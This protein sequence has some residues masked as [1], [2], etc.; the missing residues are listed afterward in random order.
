MKKIPSKYPLISSQKQI[1]DAIK[2]ARKKLND[3]LSNDEI[4]K[5]NQIQ[6]DFQSGKDTVH[7]YS[8]KGERGQL[9][10]QRLTFHNKILNNQFKDKSTIDTRDP[11]LYILGGVPGSGKTEVLGK[12]INEKTVMI[13]NDN[14]K[15]LLAKKDKS[16]IAKYVLAHAALLHE[17]ASILFDKAK[18]R[19]LNEKRDVTLDMTFASFD[20]GKDIIS[21]FKK[22]GYDVHL[23]GT[24]KFVHQTIPNTVSRF[25]KKGRYVPPSVPAKKGNQI[26]RNVLAARKL[27]NT[28]LI[29]DTSIKGKPHL[30]SS[31]KG[32][33]KKPITVKAHKRKNLVN[34]LQVRRHGRRKRRF[35]VKFNR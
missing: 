19:A 26:N 11:D 31:T 23:L 22:A 12:K 30:V 8:K 28:H 1:D 9:I 35:S 5:L 7:K 25:L 15:L 33:I 29:I 10:A 4:K 21:K 18:K 27:T 20:K 3:N 17:E 13:D 6:R 24:Q 14:Y 16:P 2:I 34:K 32:L